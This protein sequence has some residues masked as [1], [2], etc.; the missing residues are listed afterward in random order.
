MIFCCI[1]KQKEIKVSRV[2]SH[3]VKKGCKNYRLFKNKTKMENY[4]RKI[5]VWQEI[6]QH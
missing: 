6:C 3:C 2:F 1:R 4:C 5:A